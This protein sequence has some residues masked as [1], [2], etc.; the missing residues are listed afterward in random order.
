MQLQFLVVLFS[1]WIARGQGQAIE[2]LRA[3]KGEPL[4]RKRLGEFAS[5]ATPE[6]ILRWYR[7]KVAAKYDGSR[8]RVDA[9]R[10]LS[11]KDKV[12]QLLTMARGNPSWGYTRLHGALKNL[13]L[14]LGRSTIQRILR[15]HGIEPAP[16]RGKTLPWKT[17]LKAHWGAIAAADF[18][19]RGGAHARGPPESAVAATAQRFDGGVRRTGTGPVLHGYRRQGSPTRSPTRRKN[20]RIASMIEVDPEAQVELLD[21]RDFWKGRGPDWAPCSS[22]RRSGPSMP[23][24]RPHWHSRVTPS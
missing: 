5:L 8:T 23:S 10:P 9:P 13:G 1:T 11:R 3:E 21:A 12:E 17:F 15:V 14:D 19:T 2:Y 20:P 4:G 24:R 7:Q 16:L 18:F 22:L 6:T